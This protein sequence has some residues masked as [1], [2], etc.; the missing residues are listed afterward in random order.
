M[1]STSDPARPAA[2][3]HVGAPVDALE[4]HRD[5]N[6]LLLRLESGRVQVRTLNAWPD[7]LEIDDEIPIQAAWFSPDGDAVIS[8]TERWVTRRHRRTGEIVSRDALPP[9]NRSITR[10]SPTG[11]YWVGRDEHQNFQLFRAGEDPAFLLKV[12]HGLLNDVN[13]FFHPD[14]S[15]FAT[16]GSDFTARVWSAES[17]RELFVLP[18]RMNLARFSVDGRWL[19]TTEADNRASIWEVTSGERLKRLDGHV[20]NITS[21]AIARD[22]RWVATGTATGTIK[23]WEL[24]GRDPMS[25]R[26]L[27]EAMAVDPGQ[28]RIATVH[29][30][31][32]LNIWDANSGRHLIESKG[33]YTWQTRMA[34]SGDDRVVVAG[35]DPKP[36]IISA[37]TGKEIARLTGHTL[38]VLALDATVDGQWIPTGG[39]DRSVILWETDSWTPVHTWHLDL[40]PRELAFDPKGTFLACSTATFPFDQAN[41]EHRERG[42]LYLWRIPELRSA[43]PPGAGVAVNPVWDIAW[44]ADGSRFATGHQGGA[45]RIWNSATGLP[46]ETGIQSRIQPIAL[47]WTPDDRR[48]FVGCSAVARM[49]SSFP[50]IEIWDLQHA[51]LLLTLTGH[52]GRFADEGIHWIDGARRLVSQANGDVSVHLWESFPWNR[53]E[54]APQQDPAVTDAGARFAET[55]W[56]KHHV[57]DPAALRQ[58]GEAVI[59]TERGR[60]RDLWPARPA[61]LPARLI[62]L[63]PYYNA[64]LDQ[65]WLVVGHFVRMDD[66]LSSLSAGVSTFGTT[67]FDVRGIIQLRGEIRDNQWGNRHMALFPIRLEVPRIHQRCSR[68][69]FLHAFS[70]HWGAEAAMTG[71]AKAETIGRYLIRF[72][73]GSTEEIPLVAVTFE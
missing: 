62:D 53:S 51:E 30:D 5:G 32:R 16:T 58:R 66:D 69:H 60:S 3:Y 6:T 73:D 41:A 19:V 13:V 8:Q 23:I 55:F 59:R 20:E 43:F 36:R 63:S 49:A 39:R 48:L 37:S 54:L 52:R 45:I 25:H 28:Q 10:V 9:W 47:A 71:A 29:W 61:A 40:E 46:L 15:A 33:R 65:P 1:L 64:F 12:R 56:R 31:D 17:G 18:P 26:G 70:H 68:I 34:F 35:N 11:E 57:K 14:G 50:S 44:N 2:R 21:L 4:F 67:P 27:A 72:T 24:R 22:S 7:A 38:S 42:G